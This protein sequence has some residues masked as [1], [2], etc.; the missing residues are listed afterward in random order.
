MFLEVN[1]EVLDED[2]SIVMIF[3]AMPT[4]EFWNSSTDK[5][6][7]LTGLVAGEAYEFVH[8]EGMDKFIEYFQ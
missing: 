1:E 2:M 8:R 3:D 4:L 6:H 7:L 5:K